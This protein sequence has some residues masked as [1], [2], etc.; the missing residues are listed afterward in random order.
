MQTTTLGMA[1]AAEQD[2][3][4]HDQPIADER[5]SHP[6]S[7]EADPGSLIAKPAAKP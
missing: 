7:P 1:E 2:G 5:T 4:R 3:G 6:L